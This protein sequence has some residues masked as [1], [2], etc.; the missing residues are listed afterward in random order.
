MLNPMYPQ[1]ASDVYMPISG[2]VVEVNQA[3][4][5]KPALVSG[6]EC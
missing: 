6:V 5:D 4:S 1:A 3:L 2:E